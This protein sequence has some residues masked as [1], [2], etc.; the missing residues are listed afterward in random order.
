MLKVLVVSDA[1][2]GTAKQHGI[3]GGTVNAGRKPLDFWTPVEKACSPVVPES[4]NPGRRRVG[5]GT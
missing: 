3:D 1:T 5:E 2:D 4:R